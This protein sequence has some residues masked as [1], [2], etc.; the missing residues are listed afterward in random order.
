MNIIKKLT[1]RHLGKNKGRTIVT[2]LG[3]CVSVAMITAV[4][5]S[6][7]SFMNFYGKMAAFDGGNWH[8]RFYDL[9]LEQVAKLKT[10]SELESVGTFLLEDYDCSGYKL[11]NNQVN[12]YGSEW[13][14]AGDETNLAQMITANF[15]G[16][17]PKNENEI[18]VEEAFIERNKLDWKL[19]DTVTLTIGEMNPVTETEHDEHG[20]PIY[21][22][23][24][25]KFFKTGEKQFKIV[26]IL[27]RNNPTYR[28]YGIIRGMSDEEKQG[29][30]TAA[31]TLAD[32]GF[33]ARDLIDKIKTEIGA[34][35]L[36][37]HNDILD[38]YF[39][40][41]K[42]GT[43]AIVLI[44]MGLFILAIIIA[45][46]VALIYNAFA[47]SLSEKTRYLGML[48]SVGATRKQKKQ[49]VYYEGFVLGAISIPLGTLG[50]I[51]GI[52]ITLRA[53]S[54]IIIST[55]MISGVKE[56]GITMNAV[57]PFWAIVGIVLFSALTIFISSYIPAKK[58]S[59]ITPIEALRQNKEVKLKPKSLKTPKYIRAI[60][61]YEGELAHKNLKRNGRKSRVI[62]AA[63]AVSVILFLT[64]NSFVSMF[65]SQVDL[66]VDL[67]Y[68][69]EVFVND[70]NDK[71]AIVE[72]LYEIDGVDKVYTITVENHELDANIE[73]DHLHE[74][75]LMNDEVL[76]KS[77]S[78]LWQRGKAGIILNMIEDEDFNALCTAN[79]IDYR[80][81]YNPGKNAKW[82]LLN[83]VSHKG[84]GDKV[85]NENA[86][87]K[88]IYGIGLMTNKDYIEIG[89][90]VDY[91]KDNYVCNLNPHG[92]LSIYLP[93]SVH[94]SASSSAGHSFLYLGIET[95]NH[96]EVYTNVKNLKYDEDFS[97]SVYDMVEQFETMN[98]L[99]FV[100]NVFTYGFITL[101]TLVTLANI[102][103]TISTSVALRRREFAMLKSVGTTQR[104]FYKMVC[105]E[106][107]FYGLKALVFG[108][109][110]S[111]LL[112]YGMVKVVNDPDI[113]FKI[114]LP[115]Y[116]AVIL[117]V[118]II[119]GF[120]M[121]Y[122]V[123]KLKND[124]IVGTLSE[125]IS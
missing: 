73:I 32:P 9:S 40:A 90:L 63:I 117:A 44:P 30:V 110:I 99:A 23:D 115:L 78:N 36:D 38:S 62:T 67:P 52:A 106:S 122:S 4:F 42:N 91:D 20:N 7:A 104:G 46:S 34:K 12:K 49:S 53:V 14:Y 89:G 100:I 111:A 39:A 58:A 69:L 47:M 108:L 123:S 124:S 80:E 83:D 8:A 43:L 60:F 41:E 6:I 112:S 21:E 121:L 54:D 51:L 93:E 13:I 25:F 66:A 18:A 118:F 48:G 81:Y 10:N 82:L 97:M 87:G 65:T 88:R 17:I 79:G 56:A 102:I 113:T 86:V 33:N 57:V 72:K 95:D 16:E 22:Y 3:I 19:G 116:G 26:A 105:L 50:G 125:D 114:N 5:V 55:G 84:S 27:H 11:P 109:P 74:Y 119:I 68:Q 98:G 85:F 101:I 2:T 37:Y 120:S 1:L 31:I 77:Y 107:L 15:D 29:T 71:E 76:T 28:S 94:Y 61:G 64:A 24:T 103:N 75:A 45:A 92:Y 96:A 70:Y 59:A 35:E